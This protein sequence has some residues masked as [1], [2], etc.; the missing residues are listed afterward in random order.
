[1]PWRNKSALLVQSIFHIWQV[2]LRMYMTCVNNWALLCNRAPLASKISWSLTFKL[3]LQKGQTHYLLTYQPQ[4]C[5]DCAAHYI[6]HFVR[7]SEPISNVTY[8]YWVHSFSPCW[9]IRLLGV[10]TSGEGEG[11]FFNG[12]GNVSRSG[13]H[14]KMSQTCQKDHDLFIY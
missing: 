3:F 8:S 7:S 10:M 13:P 12:R 4:I 9:H 1:M 2:R 6:L 5:N 11:N 14:L